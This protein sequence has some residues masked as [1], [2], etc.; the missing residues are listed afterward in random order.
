MT[1]GFRLTIA[2][3]A[4]SVVALAVALAPLSAAFVDGHYVPIGPDSFYHARRILDTVANPADFYQFDP[5][6]H[7]PEGGLIIWPWAYDYVMSL[8]VRAGLALGFSNDA[9]SVLVHIP[10]FAFP[11]CLALVAAICRQLR[12]S[13]IATFLAMLATAALPL[14]QGLYGIGNIDHHFAEHLFVLASLASGM[15]WLRKPESTRR[16]ALVGMILG[17]APGVHTALFILQLPLS[18]ALA[19][20]WLRKLPIPPTVRAYS[21][22]QVIAALCVGLPSLALREGLFQFET[23]SWFQVYVAV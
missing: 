23:L 9:L 12:L 18:A 16:A 21:I 15:A 5:R 11:V 14:N 19:I 6:M 7:V 10:V 2:W 22:A 20:A 17:I 1:D 3:L 8:L 13:V 4:A